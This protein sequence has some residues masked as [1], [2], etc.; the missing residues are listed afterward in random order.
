MPHKDEH[1]LKAWFS[2]GSV[3]RN[4]IHNLANIDP[5]IPQYSE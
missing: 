1:Y 4:T 5:F 2:L 3:W